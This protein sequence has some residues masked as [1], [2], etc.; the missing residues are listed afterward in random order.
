MQPYYD[1]DGIT[2]YHG[3]CREIPKDLPRPGL[4]LTD[5]PYGIAWSRGEGTRQGVPSHE[6][7]KGDNDTSARDY[8]LNSFPDVPAFVFGSFYAPFPC[9]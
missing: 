2:I 3:D 8:A 1:E 7:I 9:D 4:M 5:P 6:G